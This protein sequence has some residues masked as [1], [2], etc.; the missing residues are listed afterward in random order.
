M[1]YS[2]P[3]YITKTI[4]GVVAN[5][6]AKTIL[7]VQLVKIPQSVQNAEQSEISVFPNPTKGNLYIENLPEKDVLINVYDING[8]SISVENMRTE[9]GIELDFR[10]LDKGIYT[11]EIVGSKSFRY[12]VAYE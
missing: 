8:R 9:N 10:N 6:Y 3:G 2:S 11:I 7:D 12:K 5:D 1:R 4:T